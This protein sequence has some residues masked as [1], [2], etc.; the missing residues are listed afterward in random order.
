M[1]TKIFKG[2]KNKVLNLKFSQKGREEFFHV[3]NIVK[4]FSP[5]EKV[6][7]R[8]L[9]F[10]F[11]ATAFMLTIGNDNLATYRPDYGGTLT[12][13][14]IGTPRF[15]NPLLAIS[16][17]DRDLTT[18]IYSG[19]MRK[20]ERGNIILD[21]AES[22]DV[23]EDGLLYTFK[24][25]EDA[26]FHN[27]KPVTSDD[28]VFTI[29]KAQDPNIRSPKRADWEG[30]SLQKVDERTVTFG[31]KEPYANFLDSVTLG[32]LPKHIW[33][34]IP[35]DGFSLN[36][37][38]TEPIGSGPYKLEK[39]KKDKVDIPVSYTLK[40]F[41]KFTLGEP[42][43]SKIIFKFA[44]NENELVQMYNDGNIDS[45][46]S[47]SPA[48]AI[49]LEKNGAEI[50]RLPLPRIFGIFLN[51]SEIPAL[52]NSA[53]RRALDIAIPKEELIEN[54]FFGFADVAKG[55]IPFHLQ[56]F[57]S[58]S[59]TNDNEYVSPESLIESAQLILEDGGWEK[60]EDGI[61][62]TEKDGNKVMLSFSLS[63]NNVEE[64]VSVAESIVDV[65]NKVG[66]QVNLKIFEPG[67]LNQNVI[68]PRNFETLLFGMVIGQ[69]SDF[70]A[71]WHSSQRNDPGLNISNY[72]N[73]EVDGILDNMRE[74]L[75]E[76]S[77][78]KNF[79]TLETEIL[80]DRPAIFLY[81]PQF[82]YIIPKNIQGINISE[83]IT[84]D[85]RFNNIHKWYTQTDRVL[86]LWN[87]N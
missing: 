69:D 37:Y 30:V 28:I 76:E 77:R 62:V 12:E 87:R 60:N 29:L 58:L 11:I 31:L 65:W 24:I 27:G 38:N 50:L 67:D 13:G 48:I 49:E 73:I 86:N 57:D 16:G 63:T 34:E 1:K 43:I 61:Y 26:E 42:Y 85:N 78:K 66:A 72:A 64:L 2:F 7:F 40:S 15:I 51:Q 36:K 47:I 41:K 21:I 68:R 3:Q 17:A 84:A 54:I 22:Y 9:I 59:S 81:T 25:R 39:I 4:S 35:A 33:N 19:L 14:V 75:D 74:D 53:V 56:P 8:I 23:S 80:A 83:I 52:A 79:I 70:Y 5:A 46:N 71:F 55:P 20:D 10:I 45:L 44:K 6:V 18:L 32:I 82:I